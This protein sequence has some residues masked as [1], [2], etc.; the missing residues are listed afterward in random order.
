MERIRCVF[1]EESTASLVIYPDGYR[2]YGC[3]AHG[4]LSDLGRK[5]SAQQK[6]RYVEN[7][8]EKLRYIDGLPKRTV[9]GFDL[10]ADDTGYYLVWPDRSYFKLRLW[11][12]SGKEPKYRNPSGHNQP[13]FWCRRGSSRTLS[14]VEGEINALSVAEAMP[15][16]DVCSPGSASDFKKDKS[17]SF[18]LTY[19]TPYCTVVIMADKDGA[20]TEA[21]IH[22]KGLL[23]G[24]VPHI[25][26][27]LMDTD[28]N[29]V[30]CE[31]GKEA[32]R[33]KI[34]ESLPKVQ[35]GA[36]PA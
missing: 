10:P 19:C 13:P 26:I 27:V 30:L 2:C 7:V 20:G 34:Q 25:P 8:Q 17:R 28:A 35:E 1:H 6:E 11:N 31:Q 22:T 5:A 24:K 21:A 29:Q 4:P 23:L 14:L 33:A 32:L 9:R 16:W 3:G 12:P 36:S 18:L 15:E